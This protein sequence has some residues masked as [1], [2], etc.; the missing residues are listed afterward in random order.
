MAS[1]SPQDRQELIRNA[2]VFLNDSTAWSPLAQRIQFLEAKGLTAQEI[3]IAIRQATNGPSYPAT[4]NGPF[5]YMGQPPPYRW[6]WRDYFIAAVVSGTVTYGA[7]SLFKKYLL[8]HL[9]PPTSTAYEEDRDALT[10]QFDAA[11][12]LLKELQAES[13][14]VRSSVEAQKQQ[15]DE[16][17]KNVNGMVQEVRN[18]EAKTRDEMREIRDEINSIRD[19]LPKARPRWHLRACYLTLFNCVMFSSLVQNLAQVAPHVRSSSESGHPERPAS[20]SGKPRDGHSPSSTGTLAESALSNLRKTLVQQRGPEKAQSPPPRAKSKLEDRLRASFAI[21]E[22]SSETTPATSARVS[23]AP[24]PPEAEE[25]VRM[26]SPETVTTHPLSPTSTPLPESRISSP[27][28]LNEPTPFAIIAPHSHAVDPLLVQPVDNITAETVSPRPQAPSSEDPV[29]ALEIELEAQTALTEMSSAPPLSSASLDSDEVPEADASIEES[30]DRAVEHQSTAPDSP[31]M[32]L[33][34]P[35]VAHATDVEA[36]QQRLRLVEQRF[37][38][39]S[40][41]F[42]RL[43]AEKAAADAVLQEHTPLETIGDSQGLQDF[44]RNLKQKSELSA[45]EIGRLNGKLQTQE[46]RVEELRD[47]HRL[48]SASQSSQIDKLKLQLEES[49]ALL[50][51]SQGSISKGDENFAAQKTEIEKLAAEVEQL[52][53]VTKEEEEKRVKAISL[54]KTVRQKLVKAEKERDDLQREMQALREKEKTETEKAQIDKAKLHAEIAAITA[55]KDKAMAGLRLQFEKDLSAAKERHEKE[56]ASVRAQF[57]LDAVTSKSTHTK[58]TST[59]NAQI[60][61][62]EQSTRHL[63]ND[64]NNFFEQLQ[65]RQAELES[66]QSHLDSLQ[67]QNTEL[68]YQLRETEE[69]LSLL[70]DELADARRQP[71]VRPIEPS[72]STEDVAQL[73]SASQAKYETRI[74]DLQKQLAVAEKERNESEGQWSRKL[75]E[76]VRE[77]D[78]IRQALGSTVKNKELDEDLAEQ[79]KTQIKRL[80]DELTVQQIKAADM[81]MQLQSRENLQENSKAQGEETLIK[82]Q[83]L[84]ALVEE[85]KL[86]ESQLRTTNKTLREEIRKVQ[87]SAALLERQRNPGVGY[88]TTR[89]ESSGGASEG[90]TSISNSD[91][92]PGSPA[93]ASKN[94]EEVNLEYLRNVILQFLEHKEMRPHLV[95]VLGIILHFT[96]QETRRLIAKI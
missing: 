36:L 33:P 30:T 10:A 31:A 62:L 8:P 46:E 51:A 32:D 52:T 26:S 80:Q 88:W 85:A 40:T 95:K 49:E 35:S 19:M 41:S 45:E 77:N 27:I 78:E 1:P 63:T 13:A 81:R 23:P 55:D 37:S 92:R 29:A 34:T 75:R 39:V 28:S 61:H 44:I 79:L 16:T 6:D 91:S 11:E 60:A 56:L 65:L 47:T 70:S 58:E 4:Y 12:A 72:G 64:K 18:N 84:E 86:R 96:P 83:S 54:L 68:Q 73:L 22:A 24:A 7:V 38:D 14:A 53:R 3:D 59:L 69:R 76:K 66:S 74:L 25:Q 21:G 48:E 89:N 2:V 87:S 42:K 15:I 90:R 17:T 50:Q 94:E 5:S 82:I 93:P 67:S 57:E 43:R 9:Q 20:P 71:D